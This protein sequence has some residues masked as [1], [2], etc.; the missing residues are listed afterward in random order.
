MANYTINS[1]TGINKTN[2]TRLRK[3]GVGSVDS[4]LKNAS[5]RKDRKVLSKETSIE[6]KTILKWAKVAELFRIKGVS[7]TYSQLLEK[8]GVDT[9]NV[10]K[11][12]NAQNLHEKIVQVNKRSQVVKVAPGVAKVN[13]WISHA[14][15]LKPKVTA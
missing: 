9:I 2:G 15:R 14:R 3:A 12:R 4:L 1:I 11:T 13:N 6:E 7:S 10:L 8:A 5:T